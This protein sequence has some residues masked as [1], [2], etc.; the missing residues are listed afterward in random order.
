MLPLHHAPLQSVRVAVCAGGQ[1]PVLHQRDRGPGAD[2]AHRVPLHHLRLLEHSVR[3]VPPRPVQDV[4][5]HRPKSATKD[6]LVLPLGAGAQPT[7]CVPPE[8]RE[9]HQ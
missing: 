9:N 7:D 2:A 5:D 6:P 3:A 4:E 1:G 8:L